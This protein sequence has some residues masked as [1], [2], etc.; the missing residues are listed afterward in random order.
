MELRSKPPG[1]S[2]LLTFVAFFLAMSSGSVV[3]ADAFDEAM[4]YLSKQDVRQ[5]GREAMISAYEDLLRNHPDH[6]DRARA[7][8]ELQGLWQISDP[9]LGIKADEEKQNYWVRRAHE[10]AQLGVKSGLS[11]GF[12]TPAS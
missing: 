12:G 3:R 11:P 9:T 8:L 1:E 2:R 6:P 7:M 4:A 5:V 10:A